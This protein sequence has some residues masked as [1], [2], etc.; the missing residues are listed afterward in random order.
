MGSQIELKIL[1]CDTDALMDQ[2]IH[3]VRAYEI[4]ALEPNSPG[5]ASELVGEKSWAAAANTIKGDVVYLAMVDNS[6]VGLVCGGADEDVLRY[7][8]LMYLYVM[9]AHRH[10]GIGT[11]LLE[12]MEQYFAEKKCRRIK[13]AV[14]P[15]EEDALP[16]LRKQGYYHSYIAMKKRIKCGEP[17]RY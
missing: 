10:K 13:I 14:S 4:S 17:E 11:A 5:L 3:L 2:A 16:F 7:G 1:R 6:A 15:H 8:H 12:K 9:P